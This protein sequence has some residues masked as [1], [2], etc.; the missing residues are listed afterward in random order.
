MA[1]RVTRESLTLRHRSWT[2]HSMNILDA[3][4]EPQL[5]ARG[6]PERPGDVVCVSEDAVSGGRLMRT[7]VINQQRC[8]QTI[9]ARRWRS[10]SVAVCR[11][12]ILGGR[13]LQHRPRRPT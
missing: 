4:R 12:E 1:R 11:G 9:L 8:R 2:A 7:N 13:R 10:A 5:L 6:F 3:I